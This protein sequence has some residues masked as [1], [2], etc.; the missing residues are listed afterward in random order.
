MAQ[1]RAGRDHDPIRDR[2]PPRFHGGGHHRRYI[3]LALGPSFYLRR[4]IGARRWRGLHRATVV[5]W[6]LAVVHALGSGSD[7]T[8]TWLRIIVLAPT[9][10]I[11]YLLVLRILRPKPSAARKPRPGSDRPGYDANHL[12][13]EAA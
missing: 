7:A 12:A 11:A 4:R 6:L 3:A 13:R 9:V 2:L 8:T 1:T 5:A 10:P